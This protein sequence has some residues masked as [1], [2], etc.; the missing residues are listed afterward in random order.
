M[1]IG[2][3]TNLSALFRK[4]QSKFNYF[5]PPLCKQI[6][7]IQELDRIFSL[8]SMMPSLIAIKIELSYIYFGHVL[9]M[10]KT[11]ISTVKERET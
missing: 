6:L 10:C 8:V 11:G 5:L 7:S 4:M 2:R 3:I 9:R 1:Y